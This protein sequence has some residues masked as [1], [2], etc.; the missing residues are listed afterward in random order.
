MI[1]WLE[2]VVYNNPNIVEH[3]GPQALW[4]NKA[5]CIV[6]FEEDKPIVM[7][8]RV[9]TNQGYFSRWQHNPRLDLNTNLP[10]AFETTQSLIGKVGPWVETFC[11]PNGSKEQLKNLMYFR[12]YCFSRTLIEVLVRTKQIENVKIDERRQELAIILHNRAVQNKNY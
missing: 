8:M 5:L 6:S 11:P 7:I 1:E 4:T 3:F 2:L 12:W 9:E 10:Q